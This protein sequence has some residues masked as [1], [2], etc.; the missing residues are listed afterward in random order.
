MKK[1]LATTLILGMAMF[2]ATPAHAILFDEISDEAT[3]GDFNV[4]GNNVASDTGASKYD[5]FRKRA[6]RFCEIKKEG[7]VT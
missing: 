5:A 1:I 3:I 6:F 4:S 2:L 7:I